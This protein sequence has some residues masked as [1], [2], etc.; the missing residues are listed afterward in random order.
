MLLSRLSLAQTSQPRWFLG[1]IGGFN[2]NFHGGSFNNPCVYSVQAPTG[3]GYGSI[4][5]IAAEYFL[6]DHGALSVQCHIYHENKPG[7]FNAPGTT[8]AMYDEATNQMVIGQ[9]Q[10]TGSSSLGLLN[11]EILLQYNV[12]FLQDFGIVFGPKFGHVTYNSLDVIQTLPAPLKYVATGQS[13]QPIAQ[14]SIPDLNTFQNSAKFGVQ[15]EFSLTPL[16]LSPS[17]YYEYSFT[18]IADSWFVNTI[19]F[20][21]DVKYGL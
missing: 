1:V 9:E 20:T 10:Q 17:I 19:A 4:A 15:Y 2:A 6:N 18:K 21:V 11:C 12:P 14:G 5:G 3:T 8:F 16:L 13:S 7:R